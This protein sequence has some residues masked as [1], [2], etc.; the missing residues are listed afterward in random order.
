MERIL[1]GDN[2]FFGINHLS[3]EKAR[4]QAMRFQRTDAIINV[5]QAALQAGVGG[6]MCTTHDQIRRIADDVRERPSHWPGFR[7]YP[8]MPYAH[9]YAQAVTELGYVNAL[10]K[11]LPS[12]GIAT[13]LLRGSRAVLT[14]D[15]NSIMTLLID[16]EMKMFAGLDTPVVFLQN[17]VTDLVL[18][19][20]A[21]DSFRG[22]SDHLRERHNAEAGFITMNL[23]KLLPALAS[24]G[25]ENP[26][27]C[28]NVNKIGFRMSGGIDEYRRATDRYPARVIAMSVLASGGI[29]PREAIEWVTNEPYV[30]SIL[31]GASSQAN[32][33]NTVAL[34]REF[35]SKN[36]NR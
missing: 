2:Q 14:R 30:D 12:E 1:F 17:V 4:Q 26:I 32:I 13:A 20:G 28:A 3:E 18:G 15:I 5:L 36:A 11:F 24:V 27:V 16:A 7:F 10:R 23:P 35:D 8:G 19:I 6:F 33:V 22:F 9:K 31:F 34:I 29:R 21:V 25:L